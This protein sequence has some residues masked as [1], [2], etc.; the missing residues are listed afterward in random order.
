MAS[1]GGFSAHAV[2]M[3]ERGLALELSRGQVFLELA[4]EKRGGVIVE[5]SRVP[6]DTVL[7]IE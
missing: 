7:G 3:R 4:L 2:R 6:S 5:W 1:G